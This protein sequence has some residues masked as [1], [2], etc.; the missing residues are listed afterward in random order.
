MDA[1]QVEQGLSSSNKQDRDN[2]VGNSIYTPIHQVFGEEFAPRITGMLLDE[3]VIDYRQLL[4][5][6]AYFNSKV[7]E[8]FTLLKSH[9]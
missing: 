4:S 2:F 1:A 8:A 5:D 3:Q 9:T 6:P 7:N